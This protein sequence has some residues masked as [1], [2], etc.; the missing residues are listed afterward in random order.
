MAT[1]NAP[2][3]QMAYQS[4][5]MKSYAAAWTPYVRTS[6]RYFAGPTGAIL[7][8]QSGLV[9]APALLR[10]DGHFVP[11]GGDIMFVSVTAGGAGYVVGDTITMVPINGGRP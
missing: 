2:A 4:V 9:G 3:G 6:N 7:S 5:I 8:A 1:F 10:F 11:S